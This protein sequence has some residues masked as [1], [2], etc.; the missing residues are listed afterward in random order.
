MVDETDLIAA[1]RALGHA[2]TGRETPAEAALRAAWDRR[3]SPLLEAAAPVEPSDDLFG[4]IEAE[5]AP[6]AATAPHGGAAGANVVELAAARAASRRWKSATG[7]FA[8]AAAAL[9]IYVGAPSEAPAPQNY[10]AVVTADDG[11]GAGLFIQIDAVTGAATVVPVTTPPSG[12]SYEMWTIP[13]GQTTPVSLGLLPQ[14]AVARDGFAA[15]PG[16][17]F[18]ISLE[19]EGGSPNGQPTTPLFHGTAVRVD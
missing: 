2:P 12:S 4:R 9:A 16:Q 17:I 6:R 1:E 14:E 8:A 18:A 3:L 11:S 10:V 5:I 19:P 13:D 7:F 15:V